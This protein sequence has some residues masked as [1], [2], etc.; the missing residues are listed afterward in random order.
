M[1]CDLVHLHQS[2]HWLQDVSCGLGAV[3]DRS[4]VCVWCVCS[5]RQANEDH[6]TPDGEDVRNEVRSLDDRPTGVSKEQQG[7]PR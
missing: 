5:M 7:E 3:F 6:W 4:C 1:L 2:N